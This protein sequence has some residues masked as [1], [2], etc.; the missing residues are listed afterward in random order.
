MFIRYMKTSFTKPVIMGTSAHP[1]RAEG[2][3]VLNPNI[4]PE[5]CTNPSRPNTRPWLGRRAYSL[6]VTHEFVEYAICNQ[7]TAS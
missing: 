1:N 5:M 6:P 2:E 4:G 7:D 3:F